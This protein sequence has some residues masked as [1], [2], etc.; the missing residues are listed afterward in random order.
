MMSSTTPPVASSQQSVYCAR[1]GPIRPRSLLRQALTKSAAP[2][3]VTRAL[4]RCDTSKTPTAVAHRG[5]LLE[6]PAAGVLQRHLPAPEGGELGAER[7]CAARAAG[8]GAAGSRRRRRSRRSWVATYRGQRRWLASAGP[9]RRH[10]RDNPDVRRVGSAGD[11]H[12]RYATTRPARPARSSFSDIPPH[13]HPE[14]GRHR[15]GRAR[16]RRDR[17]R[18]AQPDRRAGR[19]QRPRRHPAAGQRRGEHRRRVRRQADRDAGAARRQR[20]S[21]RGDQA[22]D[23]GHGHRSAG[24]RRRARPGADGRRPGAGDAAPG[25]RRGDPGPRR[26]RRRW[27]WPCRCRTTPTRRP[28]CARSPRVRCSAGTGSPATRPGRSRPGGS[29]WPRC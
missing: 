3:P 18:R 27:R 26:R 17:D 4:P 13:H 15:P 1:P 24:R 11:H 25:G 2:G 9:R 20:R 5:V 21:G 14:P 29:R 7:R 10:R 8:N 6:H 12:R 19:H 22:G 16:R 23:A 28:R